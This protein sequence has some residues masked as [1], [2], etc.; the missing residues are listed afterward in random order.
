MSHLIYVYLFSFRRRREE[1]KLLRNLPPKVAP[2]LTP[3]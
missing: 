1:R 2:V 3:T